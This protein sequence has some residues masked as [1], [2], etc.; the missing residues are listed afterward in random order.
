[1]VSRN[2]AGR[3][4]ISP[5]TTTTSGL[6]GL[7]ALTDSDPMLELILRSKML[8]EFPCRVLPANAPMSDLPVAGTR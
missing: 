1:V 2:Q 3:H 4:S 5:D 7:N 8:P 6:S